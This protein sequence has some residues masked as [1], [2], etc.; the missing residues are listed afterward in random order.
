MTTEGSAALKSYFLP[1]H[2][3]I[4]LQNKEQYGDH[5]STDPFSKHVTHQ[6]S[7]AVPSLEPWPWIRDGAVIPG[8]WHKVAR[9][10]NYTGVCELSSLHSREEQHTPKVTV[11]HSQPLTNYSQ[12]G[13]C[14]T[15]FHSPGKYLFITLWEREQQHITNHCRREYFQW[16]KKRVLLTFIFLLVSISYWQHLWGGWRGIC[17]DNPTNM[18]IHAASLLFWAW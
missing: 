11:Y 4:P 15:Q 16:I 3:M 8:Q 13:E 5:Q 7:T 6:Y 9:P 2:V 18:Q 1:V 14:N 12:R 17:L 10:G